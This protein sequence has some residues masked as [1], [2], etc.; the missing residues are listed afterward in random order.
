MC[1]R[2]ITIKN[3]WFCPFPLG[4]KGRGNFEKKFPLWFLHDTQ[5]VYI[6]VPCGM[7]VECRKAR[8]AEFVQRC[9]LMSRFS[10]TLFGTLTYSNDAIPIKYVNGR[11]LKYADSRDFQNFIKRLRLERIIPPFRYLAVSEYGSDEKK[12]HRPHFHFLFF[13]PKPSERISADLDKMQ[14][15]EYASSV[16]HFIQSEHGWSRNYGDRLDPIYMPLSLF[17]KKGNK[18]TFDCQYVSHDTA[19]VNFYV[20]KYVL[21]FSKYVQDLQS[22]LRLNLNE[23]EYKDIWSLVR[24]KLLTSNGLGIKMQGG[25]PSD[26]IDD[27]I[28]M[29]L[30]DMIKYSE[31][32]QKN[33]QFYL[34]GKSQP[35][36]KYYQNKCLT[37]EQ[38]LK[39]HYNK[40]DTPF[41]D[42]TYDREVVLNDFVLD[43]NKKFVKEE[44]FISLCSR[45]NAQKY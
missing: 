42:E 1:L 9:S 33:P 35:L 18:S 41:D 32:E 43:E 7:C 45:L 38:K 29:A 6:N 40:V 26:H 36:S 31:R 24:P 39:F 5:S 22:A 21:K 34:N 8:Q 25:F 4:S 3:P 28:D 17:I 12:H 13:I 14:G 10:W 23:V 11:P 37:I 27:Q 30:L 19:N 2:P 20:T 15:F 44:N 16:L